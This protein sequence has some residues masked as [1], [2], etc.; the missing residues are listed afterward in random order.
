MLILFHFLIPQLLKRKDT[1]KPALMEFAYRAQDGPDSLSCAS[2]L[3]KHC[4]KV[5]EKRHAYNL[6]SNL[7]WFCTYFVST[8]LTRWVEPR[9]ATLVSLSP[10]NPVRPRISK[11][12]YI[13]PTKSCQEAIGIG[14]DNCPQRDS[15]FSFD[16]PKC[17]SDNNL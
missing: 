11:L 2:T 9:H 1:V 16:R 7:K 14:K 3:L 8:F 12:Y 5:Q 4:R 6:G 15:D 10:S 17:Q 13:W